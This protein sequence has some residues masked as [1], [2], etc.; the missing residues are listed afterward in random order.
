MDFLVKQYFC[1][2]RFHICATS[3]LTDLLINYFDI[4]KLFSPYVVKKMEK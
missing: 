3:L 1:H 2:A 4:H